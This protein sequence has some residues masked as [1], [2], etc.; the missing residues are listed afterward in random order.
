MKWNGLSDTSNFFYLQQ[1]CLAHRKQ[2][3]LRLVE[4]NPAPS[5]SRKDNVH[6]DVRKNAMDTMRAIKSKSLSL[7]ITDNW[8]TELCWTTFSRRRPIGNFSVPLLLTFWDPLNSPTSVRFWNPW[9]QFICI[10]LQP[11]AFF[12]VSVQNKFFQRVFEETLVQSLVL[13]VRW[14]VE[15]F[16][17]LDLSVYMK[18]TCKV[19]WSSQ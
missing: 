5:D 1:N 8:I 2:L 4:F 11:P 3:F 14:N 10:R 13:A 17:S 16:I 6:M 9:L 15:H 18:K 12:A 7:N 19:N